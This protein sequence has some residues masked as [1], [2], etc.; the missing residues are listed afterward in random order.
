MK[1][2]LD[3]LDA[4]LIEL[5]MDEY[6][7]EDSLPKIQEARGLINDLVKSFHIHDVVESFKPCSICVE[8]NPP[9]KGCTICRQETA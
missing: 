3:E 1:D 7:N 5:Q 8:Q 6:L 2:K 9:I 4:I